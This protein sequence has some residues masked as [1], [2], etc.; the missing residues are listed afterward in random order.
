MHL[1]NESGLTPLNL[2]NLFLN[3]RFVQLRPLHVQRGLPRDHTLYLRAR[4]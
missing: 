2:V 1:N 3:M 4:Q